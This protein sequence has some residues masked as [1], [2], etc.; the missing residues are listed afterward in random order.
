VIDAF[1][2]AA[3]T[4]AQV[5]ARQVSAREVTEAHLERIAALDGDLGA[6]LL[7]DAAGARA[8]ADAIDAA[9]ARGAEVGPLAGVPV[10][11]KDLFCTRGL[12]TTAGSRILDGWL[13]P[14]DGTAVARLHAAG[15][16]LLG[17]LNLDEFA[18]GSS[19]ENARLP[20]KNPWDRARVPGG[21]SGGS[22]VAVAAGLAQLTL[23]TDTGGSIRQ[24]ASLCGVVGLRPT[25]GRVSRYGVVAFASSLDQVGPLGRSVEDVA[26]ALEVLAGHDPLD[27]T[28]IPASAPRYRDGLGAGVAGLR[29]GVPDEY[30]VDGMDPEVEAAVRA[31]IDELG[32][33]GAEIVRLS[34]PH[35][36]HA[37]ACYYLI[38]TAE[39]ASNLARYDGVRYG[40]RASDARTLLEMYAESRGQGFGAEVKRRIMLGT[41]VLRSGYY[42]AY[43]KKAQKVRALIKRDFDEAFARVDVVLT[44]ASPTPAF[45]IGE[46]SNDPLSM[47][48]AD[49]FT[50]SCNLAGLPG[51]VVPCGLTRAGLPVGLQILG[52]PLGEPAL[53]RVGAA[54]QRATDWHTRHPEAL[55]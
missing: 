24:P 53:L 9:L 12:A 1:A 16:V 47:Y 42:D 14:Y 43:Y 40:H 36:R 7:V 10:A 28:S 26:L 5:R 27:S 48:L 30:F 33:A 35:T 6:Y 41:Y 25:Y 18:M 55:S 19:N 39:A 4:A 23:G 51:L 38:A 32:R 15:A 50:I 13:P 2:S 44:P 21:S 8:R 52:P 17:K 45:R 34:L 46:K 3:A 20:C 11:V 31:A 22:A 54:Y 29:L 37:V 49:I